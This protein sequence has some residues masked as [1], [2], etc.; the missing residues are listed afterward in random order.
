M[1]NFNITPPDA[2]LAAALQNKI[3]NKTK[4]AGSLGRLEIWY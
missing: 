3:D 4:P 2:K 1:P